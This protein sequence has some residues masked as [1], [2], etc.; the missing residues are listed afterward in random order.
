MIVFGAD[1]GDVTAI[2]LNNVLS[3]WRA[4]EKEVVMRE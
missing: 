4:Y 3:S 1:S 2:M